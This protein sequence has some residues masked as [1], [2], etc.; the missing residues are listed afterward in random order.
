MIDSLNCYLQNLIFLW[1]VGFVFERSRFR[2][3]ILN[4]VQNDRLA[5]CVRL[6]GDK[7]R[8]IRMVTKRETASQVTNTSEAVIFVFLRT[9]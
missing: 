8:P 3:L 6:L 9:C 5:N 1:H 2:Q 7:N 4:Q